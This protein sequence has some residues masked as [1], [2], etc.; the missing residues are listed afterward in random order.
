MVDK[1]ATELLPEGPER[2]GLLRDRQF[3]SWKGQSAI[4]AVAIK[5]DGAHAAWTNSHM[6]GMHLMDFK[7]AFPSVANGRLVNLMK[8]R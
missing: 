5:V 8:D 7:S 6:T 2:K 1:V 4:G 3:G